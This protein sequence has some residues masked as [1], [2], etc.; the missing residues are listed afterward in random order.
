MKKGFLIF[1][2]LALISC[3][4]KKKEAEKNNSTEFEKITGTTEITFNEDIHDFGVLTSGE[5]VVSTFVFTNTGTHKLIINKV[6]SDCG[7][8]KA[9]FHKEPVKPGETGT[10]EVEFDSSGM[11]GK[12]YKS[13]EIHANFKEP[14]HLA[15]FAAVKNEILEIKY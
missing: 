15:I 1:L 12:Q 13:I 2:I 9:D 3:M 8:V 5:I 4:P 7:C 14:K 10:I 11:F 6:E